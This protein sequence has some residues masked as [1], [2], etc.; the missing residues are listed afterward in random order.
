MDG[1]HRRKEMRGNLGEEDT[2]R[3]MTSTLLAYQTRFQRIDS[4]SIV[5]L[6]CGM[7]FSCCM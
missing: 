3:W 6:M 7:L 2:L 1:V 4:I 5:S